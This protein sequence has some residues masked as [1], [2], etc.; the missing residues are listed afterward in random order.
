M[1]VRVRVRKIRVAKPVLAVGP[2]VCG[3]CG[4]AFAPDIDDTDP[5]GD[6]TGEHG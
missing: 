2:I 4:T 3:A 5:A 1:R 6:E